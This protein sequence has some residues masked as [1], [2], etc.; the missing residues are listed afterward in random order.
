MTERNCAKT[1]AIRSGDAQQWII[2]RR[3]RNH[4][5]KL[6]KIKKR[7]YYQNKIVCAKLDSRKIWTTL[8]EVMGRKGGSTPHI[9]EGD[10]Q[11][12]TKPC[13]IA[14][15]LSSYFS[16]KILNMRKNLQS[17]DEDDFLS[18][19][20]MNKIMHNKVCKFTF[21]SIQPETIL[22]LL[23]VSKEKTSG[24]DNL[25]MK[26]LKPVADLIA[27]AVAHII[28]LSLKTC[29][30][31]AE[32]KI[33]KILPLPKDNRQSFSGKNSRPI[34]VLPALSKIMERIIYNQI[35]SYFCKNG[36]N[37]VYQ[38]A[39]KKGHSTVTA[40][41]QM[42]DD[43]MKEIDDKKIVGSVLLDLSAAFDILDHHVLLNKLCCYGFEPSA[44]AWI[45]SYL[46]ERKY[47]V[48]FNGSYSEQRDVSCGVPQG[49][50]LGPLLFSIFINDFPL[51]LDHATVAAYADDLTIY[52]SAYTTDELTRTLN[53]ALELT[54]KWMLCNKLVLNRGKTKCIA[55]GSK[56]SLRET[57]KL[58]ISLGDTEVEQV[59]VVKLLGFIVD[60]QMSWNN[61]VDH[62][63]KMMGSGIA[64]IKRCRNLMSNHLLKQVVQ[65]L[66]LSH[67]DYCSIIW[68][69]T[70]ESNMNR[71]QVA[72]NKAAR[73]ILQCPFRTN[74]RLMN[75]SLAWLSVKCRVQYSLICLIKNIIITKTPEILHRTLEFFSDTHYHFTRQ[76]SEH[77]LVLP[78]CRTNFK[79][80]M[81]CYRAM[82]AWN[83]LPFFLVSESNEM[84]F[85]KKLKLF[86][87]TQH[88]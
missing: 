81:M 86:L 50:C 40:L 21:E 80:R 29:V 11:F 15:Y 8:N 66:V 19:P 79:Q 48:Y 12:F 69:S 54:E 46:T 55:L 36:L 31:P 4:V 7:K 1:E 39:Y 3:L 23:Q 44:V 59:T 26:I 42:T 6:N 35:Q 52:A 13:D 27:Q 88:V 77:R 38:H 83:A 10:G 47:T 41:A 37:S 14:N 28:N 73:L 56:H 24:V 32:W 51:I 71:L 34:S 75:D 16:S 22:K 17:R 2:Y 60:S 25:D 49:S 61:Q 65:A 20:I 76:S 63:V 9:L 45:E 87:F 5:T 68:S 67:L 84:C 82:V 78:R 57:P 18:K 33:A 62:I 64:V 53:K 72:Q 30:C 70:S 74:V 85:K 58:H 43:W